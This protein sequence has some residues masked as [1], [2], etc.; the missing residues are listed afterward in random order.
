M[1]ENK[2]ITVGVKNWN[3]KQFAVIYIFSFVTYSVSAI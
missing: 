3:L 2:L 1:E